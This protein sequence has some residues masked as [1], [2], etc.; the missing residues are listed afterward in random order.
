MIEFAAGVV[1]VYIIGKVAL[2][3]YASYQLQRLLNG[4]ITYRQYIGL[5]D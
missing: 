3:L 2:R 4:K 1:A 5:D